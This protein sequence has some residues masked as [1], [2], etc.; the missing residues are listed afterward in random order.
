MDPISSV[1][2]LESGIWNLESVC[3]NLDL[4][5][6]SIYLDLEDCYLGSCGFSYSFNSRPID[7]IVQCGL[8]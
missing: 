1:H 5:L 3:L 7:A 6:E 8:H 2:A 4:D